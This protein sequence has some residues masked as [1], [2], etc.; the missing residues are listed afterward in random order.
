MALL[1]ISQYL[2]KGSTVIDA[3]CGNGN[4]TLAMAKM[5]AGK[6]YAFDI[7]K[8]AINRTRELLMQENIPLNKVHLILDSHTNMRKYVTDKA[9][10]IVFNLGYL[11]S[12]DKEITTNKETTITAVKE[13]LRLLEKDGLLCICMYSGHPGGREEKQALLDF[14][15]NLD[16]RIWHTAYINLPNQRKNP[17]ELL[18]ITLKRGVDYEEN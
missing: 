6:I 2:H 4:D 18:L 9:Q 14:A 11:P 7:Q 13:A 16:E 1:F 3:T 12:A 5:G 8:E 10:V 17:P 15:E